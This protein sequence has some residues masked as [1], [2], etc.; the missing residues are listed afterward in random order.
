MNLFINDE[1]KCQKNIDLLN[2]LT[3]IIQTNKFYILRGGLAIA[4][5]YKKI[6]RC[7][8]DIDLYLDSKDFDFWN[9]F[10]SKKYQ[11]R[12]SKIPNNSTDK[13]YDFSLNE[14]HFGHIVFVEDLT[15]K[16]NIINQIY[17]QKK[18]ND[19]YILNKYSKYIPI[20]KDAKDLA[21]SKFENPT[22]DIEFQ[23]KK[24]KILN[25]K[26]LKEQKIFGIIY[27]KKSEDHDMKYYFNCVI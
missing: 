14:N 13:M 21:L 27:R 22:L 16:E 3:E 15:K 20:T 19:P 25:I 18:Y 26:Y 10:F 4:L 23:S 6:Y 7:H 1:S 9:S 5:Y 17:K 8:K 12:K 2:I 11:F 24:I